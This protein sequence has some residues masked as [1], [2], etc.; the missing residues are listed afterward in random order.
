[1][2]AELFVAGRAKDGAEPLP[3]TP[4]EYENAEL[5]DLPDGRPPRM[6]AEYAEPLPRFRHER[7]EDMEC[8]L[9]RLVCGRLKTRK[10]R[11]TRRSEGSRRPE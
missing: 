2:N 9:D 6:L 11:K 4:L 5:L 8:S 7:I 10:T 3:A 1:M